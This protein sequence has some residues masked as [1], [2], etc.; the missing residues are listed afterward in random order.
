MAL[1]GLLGT[2]CVGHPVVRRGEE[3]GR[4]RREERG[5]GRRREERRE[6]RR[7]KE[8]REGR[9]REERREGRRRGVG[10]GRVESLSSLLSS[11]FTRQSSL[12]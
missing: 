8:R 12:A 10:R 5:K 2:G 4:R 7:R 6:G 3:E 1:L 11:C 9:R